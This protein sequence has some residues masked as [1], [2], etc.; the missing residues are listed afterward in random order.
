MKKKFKKAFGLNEFGLVDFPTKISNVQLSRLEFGNQMGCS[1]CFPH[2]YETINS[3][4]DKN[5]RS[6]KYTR[7]TQYR[8]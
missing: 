7:K 6:W 3:T 4:I 2:G 8:V 1:W 5:R